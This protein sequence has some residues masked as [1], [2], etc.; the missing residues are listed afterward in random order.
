MSCRE[1]LKERVLQRA[2]LICD[3]SD[4]QLLELIEEE[5]QRMSEEGYLPLKYKFELL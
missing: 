5:L 4:R 3:I 1:I 2:D